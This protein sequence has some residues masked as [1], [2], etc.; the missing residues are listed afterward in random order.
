MT[1]GERA[2]PEDIAADFDPFAG[3]ALARVVPT[4]EPQREIW[5]AAKLEPAASL[6]YN[7]AVA[8]RLKGTLDVDKLRVALQRLVDR[9]EALRSTVTPDGADL[10]VGETVAIDCA[11]HDFSDLED[12]ARADSVAE[13][14]RRAVETP[15]DLEQ[16]PLMRAE[17]LRLASDEHLLVV[18]AHHI[19][20]DGWSF[21][22]V[23][24]DLGALYAEALGGPA[25][26]PPD[27]FAEYALAE[28]APDD[29]E[30]RA[31]DEQYWIQ[32]FAAMPPP[33]DLPVD[34]ARP[35]RR[36]FASRRED[37]TLDADLVTAIKRL[38]AQRG[39][40]FFATLL[41]G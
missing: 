13:V 3:A 16:G 36:G 38:G 20:C 18:A 2:A 39:A 11:L 15:F 25:P 4:T 40:S 32:R 17:L 28:S 31:A 27:S 34:H 1:A 33:L 12:A 26:V 9:H 8:I 30:A 6:A 23:A 14:E 37:R 19:V 22:V 24:R 29:I 5:L 10:C 35:R 7:E 41:A 21:G